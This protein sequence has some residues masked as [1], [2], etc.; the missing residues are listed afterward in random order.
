MKKMIILV[1]ITALLLAFEFAQ[2][3]EER[4]PAKG[5]AVFDESGQFKPYEFS[6]HAVGDHDIQIEILYAGICHSDLHHVRQEWGKEEF[7]MVPG[8]EIAGRVVKIGK[9]VKK[10]NVGD[11]AGVGC[12]INSC[13]E[14][15]NCKVDREQ[16][17][18]GVVLTYHDKD[19]F[20]D[21]ETTQ[22]GYS[23]TIVVTEKFAVKI[24]KEAKLEKVAPLL[25]AGITSYSPIHFSNVKKG[26]K[27]GIVGFGGLGHMGV[28]YAVALGADVTVFDITEEKRADA[29]RLGATKYVNVTHPEE[30]KELENCF[31][32]ILTT[33]PSSYDPM[34][35]VRMLKFGGEIGIV[36]LPS[37]ADMPSM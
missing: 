33:V 31:D 12:M 10:F 4:I 16:Y 9:S 28:Q 2:G 21:N 11:Y 3:S 7:P 35:Y 18:Q 37:F 32:F 6:R 15:N 34:M 26:D 1:S 19:P 36:G 27:V 22:G 14:C 20:H 24:P 8:H 25:C 23:N 17:C 13:G 5:F 30:L 29:L